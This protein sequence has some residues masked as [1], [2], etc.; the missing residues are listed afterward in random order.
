MD[1]TVKTI[2]YGSAT[3]RNREGATAIMLTIPWEGLCIRFDT[4]HETSPWPSYVSLPMGRL[5]PAP[6]SSSL[7]FPTDRGDTYCR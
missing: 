3:P 2:P 1:S 5:P 4:G 7:P 6:T